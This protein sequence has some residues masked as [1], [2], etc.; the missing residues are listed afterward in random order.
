MHAVIITDTFNIRVAFGKSNQRLR[1]VKRELVERVSVQLVQKGGCS[2]LAQ[3][4]FFLMQYAVALR[5]LHATSLKAEL[6]K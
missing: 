2:K 4:N 1:K 5:S 6:L 3:L